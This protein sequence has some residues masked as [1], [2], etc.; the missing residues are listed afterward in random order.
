MSN[1]NNV[2]MQRADQSKN[3]SIFSDA[4]GEI[5]LVRLWGIFKNGKWY[6]AISTILFIV[7]AFIYL[8]GVNSVYKTDALLRVDD[9]QA[10]SPLKGVGTEMGFGGGASGLTAA[11]MQI[12]TSRSVL[13]QTVRDLNLDISVKPRTV[14]VA[15]RFFNGDP[16]TSGSSQDI[17]DL[18][19]EKWRPYY[20]WS[21]AKV[22]VADLELP[23][24]FQD[25]SFILRTL[26]QKRYVLYNSNG[27]RILAG[28]VGKTAKHETESGNTIELLINKIT[29]SP[30]AIVD[31]DIKRTSMLS[32]TKS[33]ASKLE[34]L[35]ARQ[36]S[37]ILSL[38]MEGED[39]KK[40]TQIV[41]SIIDNYVKNNIE[42]QSKKAEK[43]LDFLEDQLPRLRKDV[44]HAENR[45]ASYQKESGHAVSISQYGSSL[46]NQDVGLQKQREQ[47][48]LKLTEL[49]KQYTDN[50]PRVQAL[51]NQLAKINSNSEEVSSKF[52]ELP[53]SEKELLKLQRNVRVKTEL[54]TA[55]LNRSQE[56]RVMRA[57]TVGNTHVIDYAEVPVSTVAPKKKFILLVAALVG[58][59]I[60]AGLVLLRSI[61]YRVINDPSIIEDQLGL[62]IYAVVP[63]SVWLERQDR[64]AKREG[65]KQPLMAVMQKDNVS[66]E[67]LRSLRTS[68]YFAQME[69]GSNMVLITGPAPGVGKSFISANLACLLA[70]AGNKVALV[71]ADMRKGRLHK[72]LQSGERDRGLSEL[73][74][75]Q[76]SYQQSLKELE[77]T[78]VKVITSG[79]IPPNPSELL[80]GVQFN[81]LIKQLSEEFDLV[82]IDAPPI[83]AVTDAGIIASKINDCIT[84][85]VARAGAHTLPELDEATKRMNTQHNDI[86]G[87]IFNGYKKSHANIAGNYGSGNYYQYEYK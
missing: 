67:A 20:A 29:T 85:M 53:D 42:E 46:L 79:S 75:N 31:F 7:L 70:E 56:L 62:P 23:K 64:R 61:M 57:G 19:E 47:L 86:A 87:V 18:T 11:E 6:I 9:A 78:G 74:S 33:L 49:R 39:K 83:L 38:T 37:G 5:D 68:L 15:G 77:D 32:A 27:K 52:N 51:R 54:Y 80:M 44:E 63:Y 69:K 65:E 66:M 48:N 72:F 59:F 50:H 73:L 25:E 8:L 2:N 45:L 4:E 71:D 58:L 12:I 13:S 60:G 41:N 1:H 82:I 40:I 35:E 43:S 55:L 84:F 76:T 28:E 34:V 22:D 3:N 14:P 21:Q 24:S 26:G 17:S 10:A 81:Q 36:D 30:N 16:K